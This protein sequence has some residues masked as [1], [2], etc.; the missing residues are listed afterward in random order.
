M[1]GVLVSAWRALP[2]AVET[3][4]WLRERGVP[5]LV[6]TNATS[7][8]REALAARLRDAGLALEPADLMT[9][10]ILAGRYL[11]AAHPGARVFLVGNVSLDDE[12]EGV[13]LV[14]ER[15]DV[16]LVAGADEAFAWRNLSRALR[17]LVDGA[18]LVAMHRNV[19]WM[20]AEGLMLDT[21]AFLLGLERASGMEAVVTGKPAPEF[22]RLCLETLGVDADGAVMVGDD[23][24]ADVLAA[25]DCGLTGILVRTG[26]FR[27]EVL[28]ASD[29]EPDHVI[30]SIADL[31]G[32]LG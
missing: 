13:E 21:G 12:L 31:R 26:K 19:S 15:P 30:D 27:Q 28:D 10:A 17:F 5:F 4:A 32:L 29:R 20:T 7:V 24:E 25:Q 16:V 1:D 3:L 18:A 14:D 6:A 22:F 11:R 2:G 8:G 23:L 9:G